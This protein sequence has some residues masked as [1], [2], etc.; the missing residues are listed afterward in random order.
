G[1]AHHLRPRLALVG[2]PLSLG[3]ELDR[4]APGVVL[5]YKSASA[6]VFQS[7]AARP[8]GP[9]FFVATVPGEAVQQGDLEYFVEVVDSSGHATAIVGTSSEPMRVPTRTDWD[10]SPPRR[11]T[12]TAQFIA[13]YADY[14]R[15]RGNDQDYR[16]E[17]DFGLRLG[18]TQLRALR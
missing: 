1:L 12:A 18:D 17:A 16:L 14:N 6:A 4:P 10:Y 9:R 5:H 8:A 2:D 3:V 13:D 7:L 11:P 15:L